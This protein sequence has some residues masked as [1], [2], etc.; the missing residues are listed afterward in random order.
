MSPKADAS[1]GQHVGSCPSL[2]SSNPG[3]GVQALYCSSEEFSC[4]PELSFPLLDVFMMIHDVC[5]CVCV[6]NGPFPAI[7][8]TVQKNRLVRPSSIPMEDLPAMDVLKP[9]GCRVG[10][11]SSN[12]VVEG[13]WRC[14]VYLYPPCRCKYR[15]CVWSCSLKQRMQ[16]ASTLRIQVPGEKVGRPCWRILR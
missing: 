6:S 12:L 16:N 4:A 10:K 2:F 14:F 7:P 11:E 13:V 3:R 15:N 1:P 9:L 8:L 5:V